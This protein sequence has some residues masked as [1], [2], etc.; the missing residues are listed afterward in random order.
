MRKTVIALG[1]VA[2]V[3]L[4]ITYVY[5]QSPGYG[6]TGWGYGKWSS[7]TAEQGT[8]LQ[9]LRQK[10]DDETAQLRGTI[11]TKR[12]ELQSLWTNPT[13]DSRAIQE[14]EKE[15]RS[16]QDQMTEKATQFKL[17]ARN[18]LT[19]DQLAQIG[20]G[21]GRGRLG[22]GYGMGPRYGMRR[23]YGMSPGYGTCY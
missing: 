17:E 7:L 12:F 21:W 10:F 6:R 13:A 23:A 22:H 1:L 20:P 3:A 5:A 15:L 2:V 19:P 8:N 9:E 18:I 14:K 11:I 16:L 4:G